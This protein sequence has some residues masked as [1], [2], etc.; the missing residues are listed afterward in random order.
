[1]PDEVKTLRELSV[2][3]EYQWK[4]IKLLAHAERDRLLSAPEYQDPRRLETFGFQGWSQNDEDGIIAEIF[5]RIGT[6]NRRFVEFGVGDGGENNTRFLLDQGWLGL[7]LDGS[8]DNVEN[9]KKNCR[10]FL[11]SGQLQHAQQFLTVENINSS[12]GDQGFEGDIDLLSIDVD[13]NDY[14]LWKAINVVSPRVVVIEYNGYLR[15]P[16]RWIMPYQADYVWD[17]K[18]CY[19]TAS[20]K[21]MELLGKEL[22][23]TLVACHLPGL[24]A[25]FV[26]DDLTAD[27]FC[28]DATA[29]NLYHPRRW[30]LDECSVNGRV[31]CHLPYEQ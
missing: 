28:A 18:T 5:R 26:R 4:Q 7:W 25:F 12:I 29:E 8:S 15:P 16:I 1:M 21:S 22:G 20:L 2:S 30:W 24:N 14:H 19:F 11:E 31:P 23:Y 27:H 6:T 9:Q 17:K 13:G 3:R 10:V